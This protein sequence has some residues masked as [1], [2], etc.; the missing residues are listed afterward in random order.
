VAKKLSELDKERFHTVSESILGIG[1]RKIQNHSYR[2]LSLARVVTNMPQKKE[3][4]K[5]S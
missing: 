5:S 1:C 2:D 3:Q 4:E